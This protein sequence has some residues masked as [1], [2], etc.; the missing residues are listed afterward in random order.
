MDLG[1]IQ[2]NFLEESKVWLSVQLGQWPVYW[3]QV[4]CVP[5]RGARDYNG[6][7]GKEGTS[8]LPDL[9]ETLMAGWEEV[10]VPFPP[11]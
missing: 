8:P 10:P 9:L 1:K 4:H 2:W 7:I 6:S 5:E 3:P 11:A